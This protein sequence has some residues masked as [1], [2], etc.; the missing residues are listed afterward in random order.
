[1]EEDSEF[2]DFPVD[3]ENIEKMG[4]EID[5]YV[6]VTFQN[7]KKK[8]LTNIVGKVKSNDRNHVFIDTTHVDL[9]GCMPDKLKD[10]FN[11][12]SN[13][14]HLSLV[15]GGEYKKI[16]KWKQELFSVKA[17]EY[18]YKNFE[19]IG[20]SYGSHTIREYIEVDKENNSTFRVTETLNWFAADAKLNSKMTPLNCNSI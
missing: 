8:K 1:M 20:T 2:E 3:S 4:G 11:N 13:P 6:I 5:N 10:I 12:P 9:R 18:G 15:Y 17:S 14:S 7:I 19:V 16:P